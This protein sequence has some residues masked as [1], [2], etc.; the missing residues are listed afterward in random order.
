[1]TEFGGVA[2]PRPI[3]FII[4]A[5]QSLIFTRRCMASESLTKLLFRSIPASNVFF[6][7][8]NKTSGLIITHAQ[9][10]SIHGS[11]PG[12]YGTKSHPFRQHQ[13]QTVAIASRASM[14]WAASGSNVACAFAVTILAPKQIAISLFW[15][16]F[17]QEKCK[18]PREECTTIRREFSH[19]AKANFRKRYV[20]R[21]PGQDQQGN[22]C[23]TLA[24]LHV[25]CRCHFYRQGQSCG[26]P[27]PIVAKR[28]L[29]G[30][31]Y[32]QNRVASRRW[33]N[34]PVFTV[35]WA[36]TLPWGWGDSQPCVFISIW[37]EI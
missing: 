35:V 7:L 15:E 28:G 3:R 1:M 12:K 6:E 30:R 34:A 22:R 23:L 36:I 10:G 31:E 29:C 8:L 2:T 27:P 21:A 25:F 32:S 24:R 11:P 33:L 18:E 4:L 20:P 26:T 37:D 16:L 13:R 5:D 9:R 17:K 19:L 14:N